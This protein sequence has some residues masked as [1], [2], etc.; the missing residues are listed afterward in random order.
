MLAEYSSWGRYPSRRQDADVCFW[1]SD[2]RAQLLSSASAHGDT[3]P[4]GMGRSYGDSCLAASGRVIDMSRLDKLISVDWHTGIVRAEAGMTLAEL[5]QL[6]IPR[7]WFLPVTPGTKFVTLGGAVAN[8]VHGK[9]H[10]ARGT[11][12][13]HVR[14]IS[15]VRSDQGA[16]T[17]SPDERSQFFAATIGGLGLTGVIESVELQLMPVSSAQM[18]CSVQ[19][20]AD[21]DEFFELSA[22][23]DARHEYS[24]SWID[25]R[26]R[27]SAIG[28]GVYTVADH[29]ADGDLRLPRTIRLGMP[30]TPPISLVN[31][32]SLML[33]NEAYWRRHSRR[34]TEMRMIYDRYF[35]PLDGIRNWNRMYGPKGFQQYQCVIPEGEGPVALRALLSAISASGTGSFLAVLKR[36]GESQSPGLLSFPKP[37]FTLA[38]DFSNQGQATERLFDRLDAIVREANGRLYPAKDAHMTGPDFRRAYPEWSEVERLRDPLICSKFWKRVVE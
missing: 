20:F 33:F 32:F 10:R 34:R 6:S 9:N 36:F 13:V 3:L 30:V 28:R 1:R 8:D 11:F 4:Y 24:V 21:L 7:G 14:Q 17:C 16:I 37:G 22:E 35:Y 29:A 15:L 2:L 12:G 27:G 19:R 26:A 23:L 18:T 5:L 31:R 38:L 25:C